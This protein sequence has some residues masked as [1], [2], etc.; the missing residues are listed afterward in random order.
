MWWPVLLGVGI[1]IGVGYAEQL[2]LAQHENYYTGSQ[3]HTDTPRVSAYHN[4]RGN[5]YT[6]KPA[7]KF[8]PLVT[9]AEFPNF[10]QVRHP[11]DNRTLVKEALKGLDTPKELE[12]V[13]RNVVARPDNAFIFPLNNEYMQL[14]STELGSIIKP[15]LQEQAHEKRSKEYERQILELEHKAAELNARFIAPTKERPETKTMKE[16]ARKVKR[17]Q[18]ALQ[19][20]EEEH[21]T[22]K[23]KADQKEAEYDKISDQVRQVAGR[24]DTTTDAGEKVVLGKQMDKLYTEQKTLRDETHKAVEE[25]TRWFDET[26]EAKR[27]MVD[28]EKIY[29]EGLE[30]SATMTPEQRKEIDDLRAQARTLQAYARVDENKFNKRIQTGAAVIAFDQMHTST[31]PEEQ[32]IVAWGVNLF[33]QVVGSPRRQPRQVPVHVTGLSRAVQDAL[34]NSKIGVPGWMRFWNRL[35]GLVNAE[36]P[37]NRIFTD[38]DERERARLYGRDKRDKRVRETGAAL[39]LA[40]YRFEAERMQRVNAHIMKHQL[41]RPS[42]IPLYSP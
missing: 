41:G 27:K 2:E 35:T 26:Q 13:M 18:K 38:E 22:A 34:T 1:G 12:S 32:G 14:L 19:K 40:K 5:L 7:S 36:E 21:K 10:Q 42:P 25:A 31:Q 9:Q 29:Q 17:A 28:K 24:M 16:D 20:A 39:D 23:A 4:D 3:E 30:S 33:R 15:T 11:K 37:L 6:R 8:L